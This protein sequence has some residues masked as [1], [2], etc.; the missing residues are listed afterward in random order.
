MAEPVPIA[1]TLA[2]EGAALLRR[3]QAR[4]AEAVLQKA[5]ALSPNTPGYWS[6][7]SVAQHA[8]GR[9]SEA[10]ASSLRAIELDPAGASQWI[11]LGNALYAQ[12]RWSE[13][14]GAYRAA[15]A[16]NANDAATWSNLGA[17]EQRADNLAAAQQAYEQ[18]LRLNP[19]HAG[20]IVNL[21][22][23]LVQRNQPEASLAR[24]QA[25]LDVVQDIPAAWAAIG[26]ANKQ[27]GRFDRA[28]AAY[29][30]AL[31]LA[32]RH[33]EARYSLALVM[34][35]QWDLPEAEALA[36]ELLA[37]DPHDADAWALLGG[38]LQAGGQAI[39]A[40][41]ALRRSVE[42]AP[43]PDRH[44]R[45]LLAMQYVPDAD[46]A[47]LLAEH[48]RWDQLYT[49][50][51]A[52]LTPPVPIRRDRPLR[53]GFVSSDFGQHPTGF[54]VLRAV[55][56]LDKAECF[57]ACYADRLS[58]D[59][60][61]AR[62]RQA[63]DL[64]RVTAGLTNVELAEQIRADEIDV[65]IDLLGHTGKRLPSFARRPAP[66][67]ATW[68]G[69]VGTTGLTAMD[70]LIADLFHV[71]PGEESGYFERI[72]RMPN[73]YACYGAPADA[74]DV[75]P[76][77]ALH[78]GHFTFG[79]FNNPCKYSPALLD[80]WAEILR[81]VPDSRLLLKYGGL[82]QPAAQARLHSLFEAHE[83][84]PHR[85][86]LEGNVPHRELLAAYS[87]VDL[88]L[89]TQPY[90]GGLTTCEA[91]WMG[92][93]VVTFP[94]RTFAGRHS[95]SHLTNAGYPQFCAEGAAGYIELAVQWA[96][97]IDNLAA[98]RPAMRRQVQ[99]SPLC[100]APQFARDLLALLRQAV[101]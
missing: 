95:L 57:V 72:L 94:G 67:H 25:A 98:I 53:I 93:P 44:S 22:Y 34:L 32:P 7:L 88:A 76:L 81:R 26:N 87:R 58:E 40:V 45:L 92:V 101:A 75:A 13:A 89:D 79:C 80:A 31:A 35:L 71:R 37:D 3:G 21:A 73:G 46:A 12:R 5:I 1:E 97:R 16:R 2:Q 70:G 96:S 78:A 64:W 19:A 82:D 4:E 90:S 54:L 62:F 42:H 17:A 100:D 99:G 38:I 48:R 74:P 8:Q 39:G 91:L 69:Y 68:F 77:P 52:P 55:E 20:A 11:N 14:A 56:C 61:T 24:L 10:E 47:G 43:D 85:V 86:L 6:N 15:L 33:R 65:L 84:D 63:S 28:C 49:T 27:L 41:E 66:F 29:R 36:R 59:E 83:V 30:R 23:L 50:G 9:A 18:S 60:L 51:L